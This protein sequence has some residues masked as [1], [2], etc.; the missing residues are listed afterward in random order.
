V[1]TGHPAERKYHVTGAVRGPGKVAGSFNNSRLTKRVRCNN[2]RLP[3]GECRFWA[4]PEVAKNGGGLAQ[5][6]KSL[7]L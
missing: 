1:Q 5:I 4:N 6:R 3:S 7:V 2:F